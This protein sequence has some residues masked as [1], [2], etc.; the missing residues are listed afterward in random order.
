MEH[1]HDRLAITYAAD[2][3]L[4][5]GAHP[6]ELVEGAL[7]QR[8]HRSRYCINGRVERELSFEP[9]DGDYGNALIA[10]SKVGF[11]VGVK[12]LRVIPGGVRLLHTT[13]IKPVRV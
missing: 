2:L 11:S 9:F 12:R 7:Q 1:F 10:L 4:R 3:T 6:D 8:V 13:E 5:V